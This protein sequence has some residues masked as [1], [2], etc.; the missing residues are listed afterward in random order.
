M[1]GKITIPKGFLQKFDLKQEDLNAKLE[2]Y[3]VEEMRRTEK[4][5]KK[6]QH[7]NIGGWQGDRD[8]HAKLGGETESSKLLLKLFASFSDPMMEYIK[9]C[10]VKNNVKP[11]KEGYDWDYTD[12][13]FNVAV[14]GSYNAPHTHPL[15]DISAAY[16]VRTEEPPEGYPYSGRIDFYN[17]Y[18]SDQFFPK[19][20]TLLLFPSTML[21]FVHPYYGNGL[22]ICLSFNAK[23]IRSL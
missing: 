18:G 19:P 16:Y 6:E 9:T 23:N 11:S 13:W 21:H 7:S 20:G 2:K 10:C 5:G 1:A 15:S 22:R 3:V 12:A 14:K 4:H 17:E 8:L